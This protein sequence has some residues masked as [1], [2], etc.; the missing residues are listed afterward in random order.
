VSRRTL[1]ILLF[2]SLA[3][4]LFII[5][6]GAGAFLLGERLHPRRGPEMRG[7]PPMF[8]AAQA[9][10]ADEARAYRDAL[11]AEALAVR[12][13]LH[14]ARMMRHD[15]WLKLAADPLDAAG[16]VADL[17]KARALQ[18]QAQSEVDKKI[19][20]YAAHLSAADRARFGQ[21]LAQPPQRRGG[22]GRGG[23]PPPEPN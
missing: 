11:S 5:G 10:P 21:A 7:A 17:D 20:D 18:A 2:V 19:V 14:Q 4:N 16:I 15:A 22:G 6:A 9:L 8:A 12:P 3:L 23:P 1:F 13:T